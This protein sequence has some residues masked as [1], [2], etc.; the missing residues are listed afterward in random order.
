MTATL[1]IDVAPKHLH[2]AGDLLTRHAQ[3][4][5]VAA[6]TGPTNLYAAVAVRTVRELYD[7]VTTTLAEIDGI[8]RI[9]TSRTSAYLKH[10]RTVAAARRGGNPGAGNGPAGH[11]R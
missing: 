4:T 8:V 10:T 1:Y 7:Y 9:E 5:F 6:V 11:G 2:A 3:T